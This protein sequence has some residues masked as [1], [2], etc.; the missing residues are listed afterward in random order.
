MSDFHKEHYIGQRGNEMNLKNQATGNVL[1]IFLIIGML[2]G[3]ITVITNFL[4]VYSYYEVYLSIAWIVEAVS[5]ASII[6]WFITCVIYLF[7]IYK[8][9]E[10]LKN[11]DAYYPITPLG[12]IARILI[13]V[14]NL[15]GLWNV[16]ST[17]STYFKEHGKAFNIGAKLGLLIPIYYILFLGTEILNRSIVS[18][19]VLSIHIYLL[20]F[21]LDLILLFIY[22]LMTKNILKALPMI[23]SERT[24]KVS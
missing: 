3:S 5:Y 19:I 6:I 12:A 16:F 23:L 15:Y 13:P 11:L 10:D 1:K 24:E 2:L 18:E 21:I 9:H 7:W 20:S 8:V 17:M 4:Y 14:Y 22:F